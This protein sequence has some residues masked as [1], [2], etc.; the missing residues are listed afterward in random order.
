MLKVKISDTELIAFSLQVSLFHG[1]GKT[2]K[3]TLIV[4]KSDK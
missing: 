1:K 4:K 3:R 2:E